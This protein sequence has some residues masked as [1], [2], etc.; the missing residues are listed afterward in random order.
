M[1]YL[2]GLGQS[3]VAWAWNP[4]GC[5]FPYLIT[6]YDGTPSEMGQAFKDH[7]A[8]LAGQQQNSYQLS[9]DETGLPST[10]S[11]QATFDG[12]AVTL[13][14]TATVE[15][16]STHTYSYPSPVADLTSS[17]TRYVTSDHGAT[18]TV[19]GDASDT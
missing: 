17:G 6:D 15:A 16:G 1:P 13:P 19:T 4:F 3:Y 14:Y 18:V 8:A 2:D 9:L 10:A 5:G 11:H 7:L 12:Q